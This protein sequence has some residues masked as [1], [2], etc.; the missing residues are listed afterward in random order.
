MRLNTEAESIDTR[1]ILQ[2][3]SGEYDEEEFCEVLASDGYKWDAKENRGEKMSEPARGANRPQPIWWD[4][5]LGT[6]AAFWVDDDLN[7]C[8][9]GRVK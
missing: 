5:T 9:K 7:L 2:E 1:M 4:E 8:A 6:D 3:N